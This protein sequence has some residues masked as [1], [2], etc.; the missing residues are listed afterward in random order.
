MTRSRFFHPSASRRG[1]AAAALT[2][3][4]AAGLLAGGL[5]SAD[6]GAVFARTGEALAA[7]H[8]ISALIPPLLPLLFSGF[9]VFIGRPLL[10]IP[11]AFWK[12]F[13]FS[14]TGAGIL[15]VWGQAGWLVGSLALCGSFCAMPVL[16]W[17]W[18]R[19]IGGEDFCPGT[20]FP[21]L[22]ACLAI[23]C[24]DLWVISPFLS[25]ILIF[26]G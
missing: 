7:S 3:A 20:F 9:S 22:A 26:K 5:A 2:W 19:H 16:W 15:R 24:G 14:Y 11:G 8:G 13:A 25:S 23:G 12:A 18:L 10:L 1:I 17:Y 4:F 21:A 6:A